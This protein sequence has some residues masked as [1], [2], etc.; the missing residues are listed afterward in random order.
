MLYKKKKRGIMENW[1]KNNY[2]NNNYNHNYNY[3]IYNGNNLNNYDPRN[4]N[5]INT[6]DNNFYVDDY[7]NV[8]NN[9][10]NKYNKMNKPREYSRL[11]S[12]LKKIMIVLIIVVVLFFIF[13]IVKN[14]FYRYNLI[15]HL[16]GSNA[17]EEEIIKCKYSI[18]GDCYLVLPNARRY[19]GEVL[20]YALNADAKEIKYKVGEKIVMNNDMEL[21]VISKKEKKLNIDMSDITSVNATDDTLSCS[22]YNTE[23]K[24]S[25]VVPMFNK[26]GY[27]NLGYSETKGSKVVTVHP[28]DIYESGKTLYPVWDYI[29]GKKYFKVKKS[30]ALNNMVKEFLFL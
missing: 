22:V 30:I 2:T 9:I 27:D 28:G 16:N 19:D 20:G 17:V 10:N 26:A 12:I 15:L 13:I 8:L 23:N 6:R 14:I 3:N 11:N 4:Y 18:T 21:Y 7:E 1:E 29:D 25:V 5:T 24:C